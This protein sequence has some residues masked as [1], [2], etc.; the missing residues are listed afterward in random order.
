MM[1]VVSMFTFRVFE[2]AGLRACARY[3]LLRPVGHVDLRS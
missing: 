1:M 2:W 3:F